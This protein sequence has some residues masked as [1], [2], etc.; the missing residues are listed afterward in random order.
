MP[1]NPLIMASRCQR[2]IPPELVDRIIDFLHD[3][4]KA[5]TACSLVAR[6]WTVTSKYHQFGMVALITPRC[7]G[8]FNRLIETSPTMLRFVRSVIVDVADTYSPWMSVCASFPSLQ[9]ITMNGVVSPP[10]REE[11]AAISSV[12]HNI[13]SFTINLTV[14]RAHYVWPIIRMFPN[15]VT[16]GYV[17]ARCVVTV[18]PLQL[19][20]PC[21]SPPI[22]TMSITNTTLGGVS[23][24]LL[25]PPYPLTSLSTLDIR[26]VY[27][28][29][30]AS[31]QALAQ[32]YGGQISRLRLHLRGH[33]QQCTPL[34]GFKPLLSC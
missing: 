19:S 26:D 14:V 4:P 10:W 5:L 18:V 27:P 24:A 32:A 2:E 13:T 6:S 21:H 33:R 15:L 22:S 25:N 3:Q 34:G 30:R 1:P 8:K 20:L 12:A 28:E 9:H 17:G 7:W 11:A 29:R 23:D 16:L 31:L